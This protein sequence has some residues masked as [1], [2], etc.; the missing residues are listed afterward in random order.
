MPFARPTPQQLRDRL[1]GEVEAALPGADARTRRSVEGVLIRAV[2]IASHGLH[3]H[4]A[5]GAQQIHARSAEVEELDAHAAEWGITRRPAVASRGAVTFAGTA[6]AVIPA[7]TELRR[8]DDRRFTVDADAVVE[9]GGTVSAVV[10]AM[11][12]GA[13][14]DTP[15]GARLALV[16]PIAGVQ[17][18]ATVAAGAVAG[19]ADEEG[20]EGLRL[21]VLERKQAPPHGGNA[22]DYR[23]WVREIVGGEA[24]VWVYRNHLG[25]G[26][27]GICFLMPDRSIPSAQTVAAVQAHLADPEDGEAP[28]TAMPTAFP[29][30]AAAVA[31]TIALEPDDAATRAAVQEELRDFFLREAEPGGTIPRS[32]YMAAISAAAG[33]YSHQVTAP[34]GDVVS[35]AGHIARLGVITWA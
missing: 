14:G 28:A 23:G 3:D 2:A 30:V 5:W 18:Q 31:F 32:R 19:G 21:R 12:P 1:A 29:P 16:A 35:A 8:P 20:D 27:V 9:V 22:A 24:P 26:T 4:L 11:L 17:G 33:E 25:L 10:T 6:G 7:G 15:A 13:A 34:A